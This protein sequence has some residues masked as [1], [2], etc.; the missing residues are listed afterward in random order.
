M[1]KRNARQINI[2]GK[3][4]ISRL[5]V[6]GE[7]NAACACVCVRTF[8]ACSGLACCLVYLV[9]QAVCLGPCYPRKGHIRISSRF[10]SGIFE[11]SCGTI[12]LHAA[13]ILALELLEG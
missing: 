8:I 5:D 13:G 9:R 1:R 12:S 10:D 7:D 2:H 6:A 11:P 4:Q 3:N